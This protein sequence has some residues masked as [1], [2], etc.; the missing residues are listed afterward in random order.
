MPTTK[1]GF[2]QRFLKLFYHLLYHQFAWIYDVVAWLVSI[3]Q[4]NHWVASTLQFL[5]GEKILELGHGPGHLQKLAWANGLNPFG[6]DLSPQMTRICQHR[7]LKF[8]FHPKLVNGSGT[9]LPFPP[10]YFSRVVATFPTEYIIQQNTLNEIYRVLEPGGKFI[11]LPPTWITGA[12]PIYRLAAW[13]F[14]VTGQSLDEDDPTLDLGA[15][16]IEEIGFTI[17]THIK[18]LK[19]SKVLILEAKK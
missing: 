14:K 7:L 3:G 10:D 2:L 9:T 11:L 16:K 12:N 4:W 6:L 19:N 17:E 18:E 1:Q 5:Y 13:L 15:S 8:G